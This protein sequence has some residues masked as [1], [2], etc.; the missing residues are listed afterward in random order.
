MVDNPIFNLITEYKEYLATLSTI[1]TCLLINITT[2]IFILTCIISIFYS[3]FGNYFINKFSKEERLPKLSKIIK[4]LDP[5]IL[6]N[7]KFSF[8]YNSCIIINIY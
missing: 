7:Y 6:Y 2:S 5:K 8:Y 1:E 3:I 4:L